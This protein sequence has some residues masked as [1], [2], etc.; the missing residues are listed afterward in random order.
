MSTEEE[1][2]PKLAYVNQVRAKVDYIP[3]PGD[4]LETLTLK[5]IFLLLSVISVTQIKWYLG[6][7]YKVIYQIGSRE[8]SNIHN[9]IEL[10]SVVCWSMEKRAVQFVHTEEVT[11]LGF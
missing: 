5:V 7:V 4:D 9:K 1:L 2:I 8:L 3:S 6:V 11:Y 10:H